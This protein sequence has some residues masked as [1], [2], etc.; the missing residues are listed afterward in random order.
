MRIN[1]IDIYSRRSQ[2]IVIVLY[3]LRELGAIQSKQSV[4]RFIRERHFYELR[5]DDTNSYE[6]KREWKADTLL[7]YARKDAVMNGWMSDHDENDSWELNREGQAALAEITARFRSQS[8]QVHKCY[9]WAPKFKKVIDPDYIQSPDEYVRP[10]SGRAQTPLEL[11]LE[12]LA[13]LRRKL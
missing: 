7:C 12:L 2:E 8:W 6:S 11:A 9:L 10:Q 1:D 4:L 5:S 3:A 13:R